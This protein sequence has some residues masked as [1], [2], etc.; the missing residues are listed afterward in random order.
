[1]ANQKKYWKGIEQVEKTP[2]FLV[3]QENEFSQELPID[4]FLN[5][6]AAKDNAASRRD[7]LKFLGF[8]TAAATLA[9]CEAPIVKSVPYLIKPEEITPGKANWY[10]SAYFDGH[11]YCD[12]LIKNREG[13]PI[14]IE[15]NKNS[16]LTK[17][18]VNARVHASILSL[19]DSAR[20]K[21]PLANKK[22]Y[23]WD[24]IDNTVK[25][26]LSAANASGKQIA[27]VS[28]TLLSPTTNKVISDFAT[29]YPTTKHITYDAISYSAIADANEKSF[30]KRVIPSYDFSKANVVVSFAADFLGNW[31]SSTE[32][33]SQYT[34]IRKV[35]ERKDLSLH[36]QLETNLS[37]TGSNA[38]KRFALKPSDLKIAL[39]SLYN[40]IAQASGV[41][42]VSLKETEF[43]AQ[44]KEVAT[45]LISA[46][47]KSLV[48]CGVND[49]NMQLTCNEINKLLGNY[50]NTI[51]INTPLY[52]KQGKDSNIATLIED[53]K[54]GNVGAIIFYNSNPLYT[55]PKS[56]DFENNLKNVDYKI[57]FADRLDETASF[58]DVVCPDSHVFESWNDAMPK[59]GYYAITQP[60]INPLFNTRQAQNSL[61]K[62]AESDITYYDYI[63]K[64]WQENLF[65]QQTEFIL[66]DS[67]WVKSLQQGVFYPSAQVPAT[68]ND[69]LPQSQVTTGAEQVTFSINDSLN[70][71]A[72]AT[73]KE[74]FDL[75]LYEKISIGNG[76]HANNPWLQ[77]LPDPISK[78]TWDN[79]VTMSPQQMR[80]LGLN[81][82][83][84][85]QQMADVVKVSVNGE[86]LD[87]PVVAQPG[88]KMGTIGIALGYGRKNIG[89]T[90]DNLGVNA[91]P[92]SVY[93]NG[94]IQYILQ[95]VTVS[96]SVGK[97]QIASTQTHHTMMGR[98]IVK[99]T[100]L[101]DYVNDPASGNEKAT[102]TIKKGRETEKIEVDKISLWEKYDSLGHLWNLSI[103]LNAC[104]GCGAC[105]VSCHAENNVPV[106]GKDEIRRTRDMFWMRIDRY[107]SSDAE[108]GNLSEME[109]A[110]ENPEVVFQ[111][112]MCQHCNNAPCE[113]VCPVIATSHSTEGLNQMTYNRCVGTRYCANNC[114]Y[115]VRRF[116]WFNYFKDEKFVSFNP[117]MDDLSRMVLNPDVV[118]RSRGVI[119]KCSMCVQRIQEGKLT[120][121]MENR[122]LNDGEIQT[123]CSQ[124]CPTNAIVFGDVNNPNTAI[125]KRKDD[126]R[127]YLL[128]EEV[129]IRPNVFYQT[130]VR[131][132]QHKA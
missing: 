13:R 73:N 34:Q 69:I 66:F 68:V 14:K 103:D 98:A 19:Y 25:Q 20:I 79:Y 71:L 131:N 41:S 119:E 45:A 26:K 54:A 33:A 2:E 48:V 17:G 93:E 36:V 39:V 67:F 24:S 118:V 122:E 31:L 62:W 57:S 53:M 113:T 65:T 64:Y 35:S 94:T 32:Y 76:Q 40:S 97:Y 120:A 130:K 128:L 127:S 80:S 51:D 110:S 47:G 1:M 95:N 6:D 89:K 99:E 52:L 112:V 108:E 129:G 22:E 107:Y 70:A 9:A 58:C 121:K 86:S 126:E 84:G 18:G 75:V 12:V 10:A 123:A 114:P 29:K 3:Q 4:E 132:K 116:N 55:L 27:I 101:H 83:Q 106:V 74:N 43:D 50:D 23:D 125:K 11:D 82:L 124:S 87:L 42:G 21:G 7:F 85:E 78:V 28:S 56:F 115:K 37:L 16:K 104:I 100:T 92:L 77:E 59:A 96:S 117:S 8:T 63:R 49:I 5:S 38:D 90:A 81:V 61:L 30:G 44:I 111:P 105:A 102:V 46:K 109:I 60:V 88:Q 15:G 91:Y 72:S